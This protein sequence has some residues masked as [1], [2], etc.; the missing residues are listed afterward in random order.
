MDNDKQAIKL[1]KKIYK[2]IKFRAN[3]R[4]I[5]V[6]SAVEGNQSI[7]EMILFGNAAMIARCGATEMRCVEEYLTTGTFSDKIRKEVSELSGV[8][9][10]TDEN[11]K[12]FCKFYIDCTAEADLL[13]LWGVG[14]ESKVVRGL[15]QVKTGFMKLTALE[16]YYFNNPWSAALKNK[17][18]LVIH[19]FANSILTQYQKREKLFENEN[20]LPEFA[21][22]ECIKAVQSIAGQKTEYTTWFDALEYMEREISKCDC[23]VAVIGAGAY[24]LPLAAYVKQIGKIA[25]QMSGSTQILFGIKGKRWEQIPEISKFFNE[26]WIRPSENETPKGSSKVEGGSYW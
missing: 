4:G 17:K 15:D 23:D 16:P 11:L 5:H 19:P 2:Q 8:F 3:Y 13:A 7:R 26:Y 20:V 9:P 14:A 25:V 18:I 22:L 10:T 21:S 1:L 6:K 12:K 24:S